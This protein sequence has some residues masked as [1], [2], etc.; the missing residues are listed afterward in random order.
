MGPQAPVA[1]ALVRAPRGA[2]APGAALSGGSVRRAVPISGA[3]TAHGRA[4]AGNDS[5]L[6]SPRLLQHRHHLQNYSF[7]SSSSSTLPPILPPK[8]PSPGWSQPSL[9]SIRRSLPRAKHSSFPFT[10]SVFASEALFLARRQPA[11]K[12]SRFPPSTGRNHRRPTSNPSSS[13]RHCRSKHP[14]PHAIPHHRF[15]SSRRHWACTSSRNPLAAMDQN[16]QPPTGVPGPTGRRIHIAH[17]RSPSELTPL[18]SM[19]AN[20]NSRSFFCS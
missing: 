2:G 13:S 15:I 17:R 14:R 19:F 18:M 8:A 3:P 7:W 5:G 12:A 20:P 10:L 11:S 9:H 4:G 6:D 1:D 16:Q